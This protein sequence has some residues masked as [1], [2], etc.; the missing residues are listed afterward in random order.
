MKI[1]T[2]Y[3]YPP[4][5][6]RDFDWAA[7]DADTYDGVSGKVGFGATKEQ[8]IR[9][10]EEILRQDADAEEVCRLG[11]CCPRCG[12]EIC[13]HGVCWCDGD[14]DGHCSDCSRRA[15]LEYEAEREANFQKNVAGPLLGFTE[16]DKENP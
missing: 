15:N 14:E 9:E 10:L 4:I 13:K 2:I 3:V 8:A 5:P 7:Y 12:E 6:I 11:D 16:S 1:K